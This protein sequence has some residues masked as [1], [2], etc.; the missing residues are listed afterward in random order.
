MASDLLAELFGAESPGRGWRSMA[1]GLR[2][3]YLGGRDLGENPTG[4]D[5]LGMD[6]EGAAGNTWF[7][8]VV[9]NIAGDPA[10]LFLGLLSGGLVGAG[11]RG[12]WGARAAKA[13]NPL[14]KSLTGL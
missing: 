2:K 14:V 12:L 3:Q 6:P 1:G 5:M 11:A 4:R 9:G 13:A 7:G 10:A 8:D